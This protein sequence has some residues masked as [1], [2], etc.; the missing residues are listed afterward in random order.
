MNIIYN[1]I[2]LKSKKCIND[3]V[4]F[5][6][7]KDHKRAKLFDTEPCNKS[8]FINNIEYKPNEKIFYNTIPSKLINIITTNEE[9]IESVL[10][11]DFDNYKVFLGTKESKYKNNDKN[12][13]KI[14]CIQTNDV[15]ELIKKVKNG[16]IIILDCPLNI[17]LSYLSTQLNTCNDLVVW[18]TQKI[19]KEYVKNHEFVFHSNF[20]HLVE[21]KNESNSAY[22]YIKTLMDSHKFD[23][24]MEAY[25]T[26]ELN[27]G[28][29]NQLF[30]IFNLISLSHKYNLC[31]NF[32]YN[33]NYSDDYYKEHKVIRNNPTKYLLFNNIKFNNNYDIT[34]DNYIYQDCIYKEIIL[35]K[36]KNYKIDGYFQSYKY[37]YTYQNEIKN[38]LHI[39]N[40][41]LNIIKLKLNS[42]NKQ[43]LGI[44]IRLGDF[45]KLSDVHY[46]QPYEYYKNALCK[47]NLNDYQ[48]I[49]F[50]DSK[51]ESLKILSKLNI[52][53]IFSD[54]LNINYNIKSD[55]LDF[56]ILCLS[57][58]RICSNSTFSLMTCYLNEM[59]NFIDN[60]TYIF[61][62]KWYGPKGPEYNT[63]D[64]L[65]LDNPKFKLIQSYKVAVIF[66][67]KNIYKLFNKEWINKC[68]NSILNQQNC[69]FDIYEINYGIKKYSIFKNH[70]LENHVFYN[71]N[72]ETHVEAMT[73]LLEELFDNKNYDIVFNTNLDDFYDKNRFYYQLSDIYQNDTYLNSTLFKFID[74]NNNIKTNMK[75]N[76]CIYKNDEFKFCKLQCINENNY[77]E[78]I[79]YSSIKS[80]MNKR[81]IINHSGVCYTKKF[82]NSFDKNNNKLRYLNEQ[83][84]C[85]DYSLF[86]R[87]IS[88]NVNINIINKCLINYRIHNNQITTK[89]NKILSEVNIDNLCKELYNKIINNKLDLCSYFKDFC[90]NINKFNFNNNIIN[91]ITNKY[92]IYNKKILSIIF[93]HNLTIQYYINALSYFNLKEYQIIIYNYNKILDVLNLDYILADN[94]S[95]NLELQTYMLILSNVIISDDS[96]FS[97]L[98]RLMNEKYNLKSD[99]MYILPSNLKYNNNNLKL[100]YK[101]LLI[102]TEKII[103]NNNINIKYDVFSC[104]HSKDKERYKYFLKYN[105]IKLINSD[106]FYYVS[107]NKYDDINS[108]H[109]SENKYSFSKNDVINYIK[110]YI[111]D[112]RWGWYYQQLLKLYLFKN[113]RIKKEYVLILDADIIFLNYLNLFEKDIPLLFKRNT[114]GPVNKPYLICQEYILPN[115]KNIN[116]NNSGICHFMLFKRELINE[117]LDNI[118]RI[119]KK[120]AW[121]SIL[122]Q[123]IKYIKEYGYNESIFSEYELYYNFIKDKNEYKYKNNFNYVDQ[124]LKDVNINDINYDMIADHDY[125]SRDINEWK[126][127]NLIDKSDKDKEPNKLDEIINFR[128]KIDNIIK[129]SLNNIPDSLNNIIHNKYIKKISTNISK[130]EQFYFGIV[131][132][133]FNRYYITKIFLECLKININFSSILFCIVDDGSDQDV[134]KE[135][136]NLNFKYIIV[137]CNRNVNENKY[138]SNNT[139]IPGSMYPMTLYIGHEL[140][141]H[142]CK[143]LGVLDSD[144]FISDDYFNTSK[145]IIEKLNMDNTIYSGFNSYSEVHKIIKTDSICNKEILYKN[146]VGGISQFYSVDLYEK[147]KYKFTGEESVNLWGYDYDY[148]ISDYM[149]K[150]NKVYICLKYSNIQHI[151]IK[152]TMIRNNVSLNNNDKYLLNIIYELLINPTIK[153]T[154]NFEFDFD[155]NLKFNEDKINKIFK[156]I[157]INNFIDK[158]FYINLDERIDRKE[159]I[160]Q[161]FKHF[162]ITKYERISAIK[163]KFN[164]K[165]NDR[166]IDNQIELFLKNKEIIHDL[167]LDIPIKYIS[168]FSKEYIKSKS[169]KN[170]R[171][172]ILGALG[173]KMSHLKVFNLAKEYDNILLIEDDALFHSNFID[174]LNKLIV[175]LKNINYD[176]DIVWLC[177]NWLYK[178]YGG[179][180]NRCN[181]YKYINDV[182]AQ[183]DS[184]L[185]IDGYYGSTSNNGG[186]IFSKK[187]INYIL[188]KIKN[189]KQQ[190]I[191]LWY[192]QNIQINNK[193]YTSIPNLIKQRVEKSDIEEYQVNYD[194]DIHYQTRQKFNIFTIVVEKNKKIY[195]DNLKN[196]LQKM[197]GYEK[198]YYISEKKILNNEILHYVNIKNLESNI[199]E[200]KKNFHKKVSDNN[201]KYFYYMDVNTFLKD[202]F[203]PFNENNNLIN[204]NN[205]Y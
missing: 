20:K 152:S 6:S 1:D 186:N 10:S 140:L 188:E 130:K 67:H 32:K 69:V 16:Y 27:G 201:I 159:I 51:N 83:I 148:Q 21:Y 93:N 60:A 31:I 7:G 173:C 178:D 40:N 11:Q 15:N 37:F 57:K 138:S 116:T 98:S 38:Y 72:Y 92:I 154:L 200:L 142:Y 95:N 187:C 113:S 151:G 87:S 177:P 126:K 147:F 205:F 125:Q 97:I 172:Y 8:I 4:L 105:K 137:Y 104:L 43:I 185:S 198:I 77:N 82:W 174:Y 23:V 127:V 111:P 135:Y 134:L 203:Y 91:K 85:E 170:R 102:N 180:L 86:Y 166:F 156:N 158:I 193:V 162:G 75:N 53:Y 59:Y 94:I 107:Y 56:Y 132:P 89:H 106:K 171:K 58:I 29:G 169:L 164:P 25:V 47:Y 183:V 80:C 64:I 184:S 110:D 124:N 115:I 179:I 131:I 143:I 19:K 189:T 5:I 119:H 42:F 88:N 62:Y 14:K 128:I 100:N 76:M 199:E 144:S 90:I 163:P 33:I 155:I 153:N 35:N 161:Q 63:L 28:F 84:P 165:Y 41:L 81:N 36:N 195:L 202:D 133:I 167:I 39:D 65:P 13:N 9:Y 117:L 122:D 34:Y 61:P 121:K 71:K 190:E 73:F 149:S 52:K 194:K 157:I 48:I 68:I 78:K 74:E 150:N 49:I 181:S 196:N 145:Q 192:R 12:N 141:K 44:H 99:Y 191:D 108:E 101:F 18:N 146:M 46:V 176:Y 118:E 54:E 55:E 123:V 79:K 103:N 197:I 45:L 160:E 2:K 17:S 109:I 129:Y 26:H 175:N 50:T 22:K 70:K 24:K 66:Y 30:Q 168:D 120:P 114:S 139:I 182:F 136:N 112:Y 3:G 204:K 96:S